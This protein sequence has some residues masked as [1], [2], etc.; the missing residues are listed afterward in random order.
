MA[1]RDRTVLAFV[2]HG[3]AKEPSKH[4][5]VGVIGEAMGAHL[6]WCMRSVGCRKWIGIGARSDFEAIPAA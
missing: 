2:S 5:A 3:L 4:V 1:D 6:R